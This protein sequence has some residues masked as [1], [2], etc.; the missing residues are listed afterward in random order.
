M[1][2][3]IRT[4]PIHNPD[5]TLGANA[6]EDDGGYLTPTVFSSPIDS[7]GAMSNR[8]VVSIT[9]VAQQI[10]IAAGKNTIEIQNTGNNEIYIGGS[11]V[12]DTTGIIL[13]PQQTKAWANVKSTFSFYVVCAA[14]ETSTL[15]IAEYE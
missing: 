4:P 12:D 6:R 15:R 8:A 10:S 13:R 3:S 5:K 2:V 1:P 14:T 7:V 11:S 9:A